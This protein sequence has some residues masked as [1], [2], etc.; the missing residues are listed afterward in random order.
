MQDIRSKM[1]F[2]VNEQYY[3]KMKKKVDA[4][5]PLTFGTPISVLLITDGLE[6]CAKGLK[7][8]LSKSSDISVDLVINDP[9]SAVQILLEKSID[10]LIIVGHMENEKN[11]D[12]VKVFDYYN[13]YSCAILFA[14]LDDATLCKNSGYE[15]QYA[16][17]V[18]APISG[19]TPYMRK[20]YDEATKDM[21]TTFSPEMTRHQVRLD[22]IK[23]LEAFDESPQ[24]AFYGFLYSRYT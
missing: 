5:Q 3:D 20:L 6:G 14:L 10:F 2:H 16:Y 21:H 17:D 7:L 9:G 22:F 23:T 4:M 8:Y 19:F 24:K 15:V 13:R 18:L 12:A 11:Y 1:R